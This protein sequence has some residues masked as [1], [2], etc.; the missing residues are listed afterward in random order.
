MRLSPTIMFA[1][2]AGMESF[3]PALTSTR[4]AH[5]ASPLVSRKNELRTSSL[6]KRTKVNTDKCTSTRILS[7]QG[8]YHSDDDW[9]PK[10]TAK[11]TPQLLRA[12]WDMICQG[13]TMVKGVS[14]S[15]TSYTY[16]HSMQTNFFSFFILSCVHVRIAIYS[17]IQ[18]QN[19]TGNNDSRV[20]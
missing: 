17:L 11:T 4:F 7:N 18:T 20:S 12:I 9:N 19:V 8:V 5:T 15:I 1:L 3:A 10:D 16:I 2:F 14:Q 6:T 13:S